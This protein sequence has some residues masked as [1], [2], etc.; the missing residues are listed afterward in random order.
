[1]KRIFAVSVFL[2]IGMTINVSA[3]ADYSNPDVIKQVQQALNDSG[4]DCGVPDGILGSG[5]KDSIKRFR[6]DNGIVGDDQIDALLSLFLGLETTVDISE[7][8]SFTQG[9]QEE[10]TNI[11]LL[12]WNN[13]LSSTNA[14]VKNIGVS[15]G[16]VVNLGNY[17]ENNGVVKTDL[18]YYTTD[19]KDLIVECMYF[20]EWS[21]NQIFDV[22]T[23]HRYY[24]SDIYFGDYDVYDYKSDEIKTSAL[25]IP[26]SDYTKM[27]YNSQEAENLRNEIINSHNLLYGGG[28]NDDVTGKWR[29]SAYSS[30]DQF[31]DF[32]LDYFNAFFENTDEIHA[33]INFSVNVTYRITYTAGVL[34]ITAFDYVDNEERSAKLLFTGDVLGEFYVDCNTGDVNRIK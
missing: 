16:T 2:A 17:T 5:T 3:N 12:D 30:N 31:Q 27:D 34:N 7:D 13:L 19:N 20:N 29:V 25:E 32:A 15:D 24:L 22:T 26:Y 6:T 18:I 23:G 21:I 9:T 28:L 33:V 4:Y 8:Y 14:I 10:M 11:A 1:M